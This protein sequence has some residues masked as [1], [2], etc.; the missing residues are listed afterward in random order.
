MRTYPAALL[1]APGAK[2]GAGAIRHHVRRGLV[3]AELALA[4]VLVLGAAL[5]LRTVYNLTR[6]DAG[7]NPSRLVTFSVNLPNRMFPQPESMRQLYQSFLDA[8]RA[9]P[10]VEAATAMTGLPANR[11]GPPHKTRV[12]NAQVPSPAPFEIS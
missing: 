8:L 9:V 3:V 10:G 6:I 7:F 4:I 5:L 1:T 2:G 12:A 11:S